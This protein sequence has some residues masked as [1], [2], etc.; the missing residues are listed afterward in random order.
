MTSHVLIAG[1]SSGIGL[2]TARRFLSGGWRVTIAGRTK[3]RLDAAQADL[4]EAAGVVMDAASPESVSETLQGLSDVSA[5]VATVGSDAGGG[6][7]ADLG[8]DGLINAVRAKAGAQLNI[9]TSASHVCAELT[10]FTFVSGAAGR[11][12]GPGMA[13]L[14]AANA[15]I[16]ALVP[17]LAKELAPLR[18]NSVSPGL[19]DTPIY[20]AM[21]EAARHQ[22]MASMREATPTGKIATATDI[23]EALWFSATNSSVNGAVIPIDGGA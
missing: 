21:P 11:K 4:V 19:V 8:A 5:I 6:A 12:G 3:A 23:A 20:N 7:F 17:V 16:E 9:L 22:L 1:G 14:T 2:A 15:V 13:P 10:S 18:I